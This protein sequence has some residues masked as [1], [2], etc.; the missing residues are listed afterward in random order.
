MRISPVNVIF[1]RS[2]LVLAGIIVVGIGTG[3]NKSPTLPPLEPRFSGEYLLA[4]GRLAG[5]LHDVSL[6]AP[7]ASIIW[8]R[9]GRIVYAG[10]PDDIHVPDSVA[11]VDIAGK[12]VIPGLMDLHVHLPDDHRL[13]ETLRMLLAYGVTT[14]RNVGDVYN[15]GITIRERIDSGD[16]VG[17]QVFT[18][19]RLIDGEGS[20]HPTAV[21]VTDEVGARLA[22]RDQAKQGVDLIKIY[23]GLDGH[24][25]EVI[26]DEAHEN[27][28]K[29]LGHTGDV[30]W[31]QAAM[32]GIDGL[33]HSGLAGPVSELL[34][35]EMQTQDRADNIE[36]WLDVFE[37]SGP[38]LDTLAM[39]LLQHGVEINPTLGL[40]Y[41]MVYG[42]DAAAIE[43]Y[44]PDHRASMIADWQDQPHP[45]SGPLVHFPDSRR[46]ELYDTFS[47]IVRTLAEHGVLITTGT[48]L[49]VPW[50]TPG[51]AEHVEMNLLAEAGLSTR[52]VLKAATRN[53]AEALG[54]SSTVG[55]VLTGY[56]ADLIILSQ[57]PMR[58]IRNTRCI[59]LVIADGTA[60]RPVDLVPGSSRG[61]PVSESF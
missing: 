27:N 23:T 21:E 14:V 12:Y 24:L 13:D 22:V 54:I 37:I 45:F 33:T 2:C 57:D 52:D 50:M 9:D 53:G 39:N 5:S 35:S 51:L 3:C 36:G 49:G 10:N 19:G 18:S 58:D 26:I 11:V 31:S 20:V 15:D 46:D 61:C 25:L 1:T 59:E 30:S 32:L 38:P 55:E 44:L 16:L 29:V 4:G 40:T 17:P 34:S 8:I 56:D 47:A 48:D 43:K 7:D 60:Y 41:A 28:L 6:D 42:T